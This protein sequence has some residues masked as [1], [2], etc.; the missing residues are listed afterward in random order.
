MIYLK[1]LLIFLKENNQNVTSF[2]FPLGKHEKLITLFESFCALYFFF[3]INK[4]TYYIL[5]NQF[6]NPCKSKI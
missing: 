5:I 2:F 4:D 6:I 1:F 3:L